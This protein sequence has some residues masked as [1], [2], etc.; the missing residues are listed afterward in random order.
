MPTRHLLER[1]GLCRL[2]QRPV[3]QE[4][5]R[6]GKVV[7]RASCYP[8]DSE[9]HIGS[10]PERHKGWRSLLNPVTNQCWLAAKRT[11]CLGQLPGLSGRKAST[12]AVTAAG[13]QFAP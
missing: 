3:R 9:T 2:R 12:A 8:P 10:M 4:W 5:D 11:V 6:L 1:S 7:C 13:D